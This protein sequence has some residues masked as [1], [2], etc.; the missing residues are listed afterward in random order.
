MNWN[1]KI[2]LHWVKKWAT[3]VERV[4][5]ELLVEAQIYCSLLHEIHGGGGVT[6]FTEGGGGEGGFKWHH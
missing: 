6:K 1:M 4:A 5:L 3:N 2:W